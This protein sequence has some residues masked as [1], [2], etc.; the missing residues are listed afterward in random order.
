MLWK[1][2]RLRF[3]NIK[4][5]GG[6]DI[7]R[8]Y[9][10]T[11]L[12]QYYFW[13][14]FM[15]VTIEEVLAL[16]P[17]MFPE[18]QKI[19]LE[20]LH[21]NPDNPGPSIT[22]EKIQEMADDLALRGLINPIKVWALRANPLRPGVTLHADNPRLRGDGQPWE[23]KDFN[24]EILA[25]EL[26]YR[27]A[28]RLQ[29]KDIDG[30]ILNP[31]PGE[32]VDIA[33]IDNRYRQR[34]WFADWQTIENRI[35]A[36]PTLSLDMVSRR[37]G[38]DRPKVSKAYGVLPLLNDSSRE[39]IRRTPT[40]S[41]TG[42]LGISEIAATHLANLGPGTGLKPGP[43]PKTL[44]EGEIPQKLWPY[45]PI[46]P[47]T[48]DQVKRALAVAIDREM[49]END[50]KR[51]VAEILAGTPPEE[52]TVKNP[53][54]KAFASEPPAKGFHPGVQAVLGHLKNLVETASPPTPP[55]SGLK[56]SKAK[57]KG[58]NPGTSKG[59]KPL[60]LRFLVWAWTHFS[61]LLF[62]LFALPFRM[63]KKGLVRC[64]E[65]HWV[66][67]LI[68]LVFTF[69]AF[70]GLLWLIHHP[71]RFIRAVAGYAANAYHDVLGGEESK[72]TQE[73][74]ASKPVEAAPTTVP[75]IV[76]APA[77]VKA[78][79][80]P[81]PKAKRVSAKK[82]KQKT[83]EPVTANPALA[84]SKPPSD[85]P[86]PLNPMDKDEAF[87]LK[88]AQALYSIGY[89]NYETQETTLLGWVTKDYA[90]DLKGHYF[91]PY[92][93]KNMVS[94]H[95]TRTF[96]ADSPVKWVSS[97][98]TTG[99]F[100]VSGTITGQGEWNGQPSNSIKHVKARFDIIHDP[101]GKALVKKISEETTE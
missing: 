34:G 80:V 35:K 87:V 37:L 40:N 9:L 38:M 62:R 95:R 66:D 76:V 19:P 70:W 51:H 36:E 31:T 89:L 65:G 25:G 84:V 42:N 11:R 4:K 82:P 45:H 22:E 12:S 73:A 88:F 93:L 54:A 55:P 94:I 63:L 61:M 75:T 5:G 15:S 64:L 8:P 27:G 6:G 47:E 100:T 46:S 10:S 67:G 72:P 33:F 1:S 2:N 56:G 43:K 48:L 7:R 79:S 59:Q 20:N 92:I 18:K 81:Q 3:K 28:S 32:A 23:V 14:V 39:L 26:R 57:S 60:W 24:W 50:V 85:A 17:E 29:W 30:Y 101:Q 83:P 90:G 97:N 13:E 86:Q 53:K 49:T 58:P 96:T 21:P 99:E 77:I 52:T 41:G 44:A 98:E 71:G 91:N 78:P 16:L 74:P 68:Q 69:V